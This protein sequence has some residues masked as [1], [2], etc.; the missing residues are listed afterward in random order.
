MAPKKAA[1]LVLTTL[2]L[3]LI[4]FFITWDLRAG[5]G[6][7]VLSQ[8]ALNLYL[9]EIDWRPG[10]HERVLTWLILIESIAEKGNP[11]GTE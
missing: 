4:M 6:H 11:L 2:R 8:C 1:V 5:S 3:T 9:A 10:H 7:F